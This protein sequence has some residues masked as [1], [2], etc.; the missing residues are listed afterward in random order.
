[1]TNPAPILAVIQGKQLIPNH[2][3]DLV[4][5][6]EWCRTISPVNWLKKQASS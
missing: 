5:I 3:G 2:Y 6:D 1:M 4:E